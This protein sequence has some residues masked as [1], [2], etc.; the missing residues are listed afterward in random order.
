MSEK[1]GVRRLFLFTVLLSLPQA[2][3]ED[4]KRG[5]TK[6]C[7]AGKVARKEEA[8]A[9]LSCPVPHTAWGTHT[10]RS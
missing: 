4:E 7:K 3:E 8:A 1:L 2:Q 10:N 5:P 6:Q 9:E